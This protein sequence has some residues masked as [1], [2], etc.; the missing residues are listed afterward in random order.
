MASVPSLDPGSV[1][2]WRLEAGSARLDQCT[3]L[4]DQP[5]R[6]RAARFGLPEQQREFI[7][8]RAWLRRL[9]GAYLGTAP[10]GI[11]L[12]Y[13][14]QGKPRLADPASTS[15][16]FNVAHSGGS[17]LLAFTTDGPIGVDIERP[18]RDLEV[19][20]LVPTLFTPRERHQLARLEPGLRRTGFFRLWTGKEAYL[21]AIGRGASLPRQDFTVEL[22]DPGVITS[23]KPTDP[24]LPRLGVQ[25]LSLPT[26]LVGAVCRGAPPWRLAILDPIATLA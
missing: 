24:G 22:A 25:W 3:P 18:G 14:P 15:L 12:D 10:S 4:L 7:V 6:E 16:E 8:T 1:Q 17:A 13:G 9:L 11:R 5:E 23:V 19:D 2:V 26:G 21:K 20:D